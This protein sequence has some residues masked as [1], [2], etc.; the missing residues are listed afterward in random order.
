MNLIPKYLWE[1][2]INKK[3]EYLANQLKTLN[4]NTKNKEGQLKELQMSAKEQIGKEVQS[5]AKP[6]VVD[7][8]KQTVLSLSKE[9]VPRVFQQ[10]ITDLSLLKSIPNEPETLEKLELQL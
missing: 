8:S 7:L 1:L 6:I 5:T 2:I 3:R 10:Y 9:I 4:Q